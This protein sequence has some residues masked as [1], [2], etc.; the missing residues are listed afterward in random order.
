MDSGLP[1]AGGRQTNR[2]VKAANEPGHDLRLILP[3]GGQ[4]D[5]TGTQISAYATAGNWGAVTLD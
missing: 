2:P 5:Q 4:F 1:L 3:D